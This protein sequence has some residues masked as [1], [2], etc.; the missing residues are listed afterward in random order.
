MEC[1]TYRC[2][3]LGFGQMEREAFADSCVTIELG[4]LIDG[5]IWDGVG[6]LSWVLM[7]T[8]LPMGQCELNW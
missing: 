7:P 2:V 1:D 3:R 5:V 6:W 4:G 8:Y